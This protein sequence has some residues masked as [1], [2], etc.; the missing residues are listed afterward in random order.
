MRAYLLGAAAVALAGSLTWS[1]MAAYRYG[2][3]IE[4]AS[5]AAKINLENG[6][7][8]RAAEEWRAEFRRCVGAGRVFNFEAGACQH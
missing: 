7:A 6:N 8:G 4:Q 2:R 5:F 1:H 3:S